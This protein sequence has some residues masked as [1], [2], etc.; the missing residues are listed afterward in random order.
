[1]YLGSAPFCTVFLGFVWNPESTKE[2]NRGKN[3]GKV[4]GNKIWRKIKYRFEP[5]KLILYVYSN[6]FY[7]FVSII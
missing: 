3:R 5:Y 2:T 4:K 7:L 1:M 6:L